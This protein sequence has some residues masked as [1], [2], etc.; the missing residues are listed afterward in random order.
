[1]VGARQQTCL[2]AYWDKNGL[3]GPRRPSRQI[4]RYKRDVDGDVICY[5]LDRST[6][7]SILS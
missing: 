5:G 4:A 7:G 1:M 2:S 3:N 6:I